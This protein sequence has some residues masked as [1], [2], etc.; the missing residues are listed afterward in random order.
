MRDTF[1]VPPRRSIISVAAAFMGHILAQAKIKCKPKLTL[2][3]LG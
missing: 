2:R 1:A 3:K